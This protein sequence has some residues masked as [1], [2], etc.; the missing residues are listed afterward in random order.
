MLV[1]LEVLDADFTNQ[2]Q[3]DAWI[4]KVDAQ[5]ELEW[6]KTIGGSEIDFCMML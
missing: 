2:G 4:L 5:G 1:A 3:N 6:Q